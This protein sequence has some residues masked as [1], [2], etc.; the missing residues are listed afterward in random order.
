M[1]VA[2]VVHTKNPCMEGKVV[3]V[4]ICMT[5]SIRVGHRYRPPD[6]SGHIVR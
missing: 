5:M 4:P 6:A 1:D 2:N 3:Y